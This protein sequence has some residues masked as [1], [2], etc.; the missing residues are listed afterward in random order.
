M[1]NQRWILGWI[2]DVPALQ[3]WPPTCRVAGIP[4]YTGIII[5][6]LDGYHTHTHTCITLQAEILG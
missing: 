2:P 5:H 3:W 4:C 1:V 6:V